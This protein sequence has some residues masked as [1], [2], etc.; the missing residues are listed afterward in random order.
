M[1][2]MFMKLGDF[3][4]KGAG[5]SILSGEGDAPGGWFAITSLNWGCGRKGLV[6]DVGNQNNRDTGD[7]GFDYVVVSKEMDG[8]S[9]NI[10]SRLYVPGDD[11]DIVDVF[12]TK[13]FGNENKIYFHI[14]LSQSRVCTYNFSVSDGIIPLETFSLSYSK[15]QLKH[16]NELPGGKLEAGGDVTYNLATN[17]PE[18]FAKPGG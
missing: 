15:I 12:V 17:L 1:A 14:Q 5:T 16:W 4:P 10:L 3:K 7:L 8:A 11:G 2:N 13:R 6:M 18:S 9:E